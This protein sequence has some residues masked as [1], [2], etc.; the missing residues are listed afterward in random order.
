MQVSNIK[1]TVPKMFRCD[2][3]V[4]IRKSET[5]GKVGQHYINQYI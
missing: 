1:L 4:G 2:H 5:Y 3:F